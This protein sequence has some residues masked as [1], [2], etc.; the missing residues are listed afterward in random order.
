MRLIDADALVDDIERRLCG[1]CRED[2][3]NGFICQ[4]CEVNEMMCEIDEW[5]TAEDAP[6]RLITA[7]DFDGSADVDRRGNLA[8]WIEHR[9]DYT[10]DGWGVTNRAFLAGGCKTA[11][12]WTERPTKR[13]MTGM[14]W[15][16]GA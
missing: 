1:P 10:R 12:Y 15:E 8:C 6:A 5:P 11:R 7:G 3:D 2:E 9:G 13:Q 14:P 16:D 4:N